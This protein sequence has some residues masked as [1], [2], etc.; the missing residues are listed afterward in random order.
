MPM[1]LRNA[2]PAQQRRVTNVLRKYIGIICHI[3]MDDIVIWS[4]CLEEHERNV[5]TIMNAL[6]EARLYVNKKK[7]CLFSHEINFL[8]HIISQRGIEAD[9]EKVSKIID[10]PRPKNVKQVQ[11]FLGLVRYLNAFLPR[12]AEQT[13]I[14]SKLT[15]KAS[16]KNFPAW[17]SHFQ[18]A[19]DKI[20]DI[21]ISR[22]CLTVIDHSKLDTNKI[23]L[24]TDASDH[25][26]GAV[27]SFGTNWETARPVAFDSSSFKEAELNYPVHEKE[28]LAVI[29]GIR[30]WRSDLLGTT[31]FVYTDHKTLLNFDTQKDLSRRQARW[32]EEMSMFDC[33]FVY[34]KGDDNSIADALSR[35]PI[36][37]VHS[38]HVA[39]NA[40]Q[41]PHRPLK[42]NNI[43]I[44]NRSQQKYSPLTSVAALSQANPQQTKLEFSIDDDTIN[45]IKQG[46]DT[47]PW[48]KK[49]L[50]ASRGMQE[51]H[52]KD[53]LWF[54]NERLIIPSDG[55][56]R[57]QIFRLAHD[58]LGHF[59]FHKTYE[60]IRNSYFWPNMRTDLEHGYIPSC[61]ECQRNKSTSHKPTGPLHP[62]PVPDDRCESVAMD[63]I[64]PLPTDEGHDCILTISDRLG[65]DVR[66][67]PT[68]IHLTAPQLAVIFFDH[69]YCENGLPLEIVSDRDKLFMS[70]FWKHLNIITGIKSK[71]SSSYH[72]QTNGTSER[73]NK[74]VNQCIRFHV[75]RNQKGWVRALPRIRFHIMCTVNKSTGFSPFHLRFGRSPRILPPL[76]PLPP[77]P[78]RDHIDARHI[79]EDLQIDV[80]DARDNLMLAKISQAHF[81]NPNRAP[82]FPFKTGQKI[83]LNTLNRRRDYKTK[84]QK[85]AAKFMPRYDGPYIIIDTHLD[86]STVTLDMPNAPN[87]FPTFHTSHIKPWRP[88]DDEKYPSRTLDSPGPIIIDGIEEFL[89]DSIID[90]RKIGRGFR[91]LVHFQGCGSEDDR[92]IAGREMEDNEALDVYQKKH[93][94]VFPPIPNE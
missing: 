92:W 48:C 53:G 57:E 80:A 56:I 18:S 88:N 12:L 51:I 47:D 72:P 37:E 59:G 21:I 61:I 66:I 43:T 70:A 22:E 73:T 46:Y 55:G 29:R 15:T 94:D 45:K 49:L 10:W 39:E 1:G 32:M 90:H 11:Q 31:F 20:K 89:V 86:A 38:E 81:A 76:L 34:I 65:A 85:R 40:A 74:T 54:V 83:M 42:K 35:Y 78:S 77:N 24:T 79:I 60:N 28:L 69:W 19:F 36:N 67:I 17:D 87:L 5:R 25:S 93:P 8:G 64:G 6:Q 16:E 33:K 91:Y 23:F 58:T 30:K 50:T 84:G 4:Q 62:L 2:P 7:T 13:L 82:D 3:Y 27:L 44:L 63:F 41:H 26:S 68:S 14:L 9:T 52:I 71:A 75:E